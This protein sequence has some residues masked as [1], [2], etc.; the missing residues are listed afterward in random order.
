MRASS[1]KF[2]NPT[3]VPTVHAVRSRSGIDLDWFWFW[4]RL[5]L[6]LRQAWVGLRWLCFALLLR[7]Q[8]K[9]A[10]RHGWSPSVLQNEWLQL[11][12]LEEIHVYLHN[13]GLRRSSF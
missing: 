7:G 5:R 9:D 13:A 6:K 11:D 2:K 12:G 3:S 10:S 4:F 8:G 1:L